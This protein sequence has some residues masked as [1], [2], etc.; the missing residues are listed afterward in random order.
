MKAPL[1][2]PASR[3][4]RPVRLLVAC[5]AFAVGAAALFFHSA[6]ELVHAAVASLVAPL[7]SAVP[8][9]TRA[10]T[11]PLATPLATAPPDAAS[12]LAPP[13]RRLR[14]LLYVYD[15]P[16]SLREPCLWPLTC[17]LHAAAAASP[18][19]T[20]DAGEADYFWIPHAMPVAN[21]AQLRA[22]LRFVVQDNPWFNATVQRKQARHIMV[23]SCD[24]GPS[25]CTWEALPCADERGLK[26]WPAEVNP[27]SADR[28]LM[29]LSLN[30]VRDGADAGGGCCV[31][32]FQ[33]GRDVVL[34]PLTPGRDWEPDVAR[35][36]R[37]SPW[38]ASGDEEQAFLE[39]QLPRDGA[40]RRDTLLW[41]AGALS[42][43]SASQ[44]ATD[45]TGRAAPFA[46][47]AGADARDNARPA[48]GLQLLDTLSAPAGDK[49]TSFEDWAPRS[50]FCLDP[51]GTHEG[52]AARVVALLYYGCIPL[53]TRP[54]NV[55]LIFDEHPGVDWS[56]FSVAVPAP[57]GAAF[58]ATL[59]AALAEA[60]AP[61]ALKQRRAS[62]RTVYP[63][64]LWSS[65]AAGGSVAGE[66]TGGQER[67]AWATLLEILAARLQLT[68]AH[69]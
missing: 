69:G 63:R 61:A 64:F 21:D 2:A 67:D 31:G 55:A 4:A 56:L 17:R 52:W 59:R 23:F 28:A 5:A 13:A 7:P 6:D 34:P 26:E 29:F 8:E 32:C 41:F 54:S 22:I 38:L 60:R 10:A 46:A 1:G 35:A 51:M 12:P 47:F 65:L 40:P 30:G 18:H 68:H 66:H 50:L 45:R 62:A 53:N 16:E 27:A 37:L 39:A 19:R 15:L 44:A 25:P 3:R 58:N 43:G 42:Q 11:L 48:L 20:L 49:S 24:H 36:K 9:T 33:A 57:M 14:P